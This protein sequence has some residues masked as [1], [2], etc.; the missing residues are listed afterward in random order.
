MIAREGDVAPGTG[1]LLFG[2][3]GGPVHGDERRGT[4]PVPEHALGRRLSSFWAWDP[5]LGLQCLHRGNQPVEVQPGVFKTPATASGVQF[6]NGN[7]RPLRFANDGTVVIK[8]SMNDGTSY[9]SQAMFKVRIGS[10]TG[11]SRPR[12]PKRP[13]G[14]TSST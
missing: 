11:H 9:A 14:P 8:L 2:Q 6:T 12:S 13:A 3:I 4:D 10:L 5:V 1:G 7:S